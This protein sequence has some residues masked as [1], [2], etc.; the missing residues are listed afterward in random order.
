[1]KASGVSKVLQVLVKTKY[2]GPERLQLNISRH[3]LSKLRAS[4]G[5]LFSQENPIFPPWKNEVAILALR[6]IKNIL[7]A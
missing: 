3:K 2:L 7:D 4:L 6:G 1:L 5:T